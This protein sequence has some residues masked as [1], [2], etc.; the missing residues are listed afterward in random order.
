MLTVNIGRDIVRNG[1]MPET[2]SEADVVW[3]KKCYCRYLEYCDSKTFNLDV[4][5]NRFL[6]YTGWY[7]FF[8]VLFLFAVTEP[9][10]NMKYAGIATDGDSLFEWYHY[11]LGFYAISQIWHDYLVL[12]SLSS[13]RDFLKFWRV[14][15]AGLHWFLL[16]SLIIRFVMTEFYPCEYDSDQKVRVCPEDY[17]NTREVLDDIASG[18]LALCVIETLFG[19]SYW[20]QLSPRAGHLATTLSKAVVDFF[21]V[22]PVFNMLLVAWTFGFIQ[23]LS[24]Y[25]IKNGTEYMTRF[26]GT[27]LTLQYEYYIEEARMEY[28]EYQDDGEMIEDCSHIMGYWQVASYLFW[29]IFDPGPIDLGFPEGTLREGFGLAGLFI[30]EMFTVI[31]FLNLMIAVMNNTVQK[32][33]GRKNLYWRFVRIGIWI[34]FFDGTLA[35]PPPFTIINMVWIVFFGCF[36]L[37]RKVSPKSHKK[38]LATKLECV[39]SMMTKSQHHRQYP[40]EGRRKHALLMKKLAE[41]FLRRRKMRAKPQDLKKEDLIKLKKDIVDDILSG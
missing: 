11:C 15:N 1:Y 41:S 12:S 22:F 31:I 29:A 30:Y 8:I 23:T 18:T 9:V 26:N 35:I 17:L 20:L 21:A 39:S 3:Y 28:E 5:F 25:E 4:P 40:M 33:Q 6:S 38:L 7:L 32:I 2:K 19:L 34:D 13:I 37:V 10:K 36:K 24:Y 27:N 14:F 16:I